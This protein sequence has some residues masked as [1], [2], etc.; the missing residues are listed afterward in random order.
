MECDKGDRGETKGDEARQA[1]TKADKSDIQ[2]LIWD[3]LL[4]A[5]T[6]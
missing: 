4:H 6:D 2:Y 1:K 5:S 3:Q